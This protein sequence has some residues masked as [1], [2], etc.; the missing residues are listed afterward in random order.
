M[1]LWARTNIF[2]VVHLRPVR[3]GM[4]MLYIFTSVKQSYQ[5]WVK[6]KTTQL[7]RRRT[8]FLVLEKL[9]NSKSL[10]RG[11]LC[12]V[13]MAIFL[14]SSY[15]KLTTVFHVTFHYC[16]S[17]RVDGTMLKKNSV[18]ALDVSS[19]V[20]EQSFVFSRCCLIG[21]HSASEGSCVGLLSQLSPRLFGVW[22]S[23][24]PA[25]GSCWCT[26]A[27]GIGNSVVGKRGFT[28]PAQGQVADCSP[29]YSLPWN[30]PS[31][32]SQTVSSP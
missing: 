18:R 20:P 1:Q 6:N 26:D 14:D 31:L 9:E 30:D 25:Q 12:E 7:I 3:F 15:S 17:I 22:G 2:Q 27:E 11:T 32:I 29:F 19:G 21:T 5:N 24:P 16:P 28:R 10:I 4:C 23:N 8:P 13:V